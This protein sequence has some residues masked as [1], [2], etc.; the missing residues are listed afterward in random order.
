LFDL[1][2]HTEQTL[3][4][5][6]QSHFPGW[7]GADL[8]PAEPKLVTRSWES[9]GGVSGA[10]REKH[11]PI[12]PKTAEC[13]VAEPEFA[14]ERADL[15]RQDCSDHRPRSTRV[16]DACGPLRASK[17]V[18]ESSL[19]FERKVGHMS[20]TVCRKIDMRW[21]SRLANSHCRIVDDCFE[22][23]R[24]VIVGILHSVLPSLRSRTGERILMKR[25]C[26]RDGNVILYFVRFSWETES[27]T[28]LKPVCQSNPNLELS[29]R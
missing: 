29:R 20:Q 25:T 22:I 12:R 28:R 27:R 16:P 5:A 9:Q 21:E 11:S 13:L 8:P 6:A 10:Q 4:N 17:E 2:R 23:L 3:S 14:Q 7:V 24:F 18:G 1:Q 19:T 26:V 15:C